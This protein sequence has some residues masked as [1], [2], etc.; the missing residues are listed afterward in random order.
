MQ[1][2]LSG[3]C[4]LANTAFG[5][6]HILRNATVKVMGNHDHIESFLGGVHGV[7]SCRARGRWD[8]LALPAHSD[9]V[10]SVPAAGAFGVKAVNSSALEGGDCIFDK[11]AL[12]Q[13]V[14]VDKN[15]HVHVIRDGEAAIDCG[16]RR[17]P[18]FMKFQAARAGL[19]LLNQTRRKTGIALSEKAEIDW[20][21]VG[22][23]EHAP[24]VPRSW[25]TGGGSRTG[26]WPGSS[27]HHRGKAG[28]KRLFDLLR[29]DVMNMHVDA[30]SSDNIAFAGNHLGSRPDDKRHIGLH[31]GIASLADRGNTPILKPDIGF[32]NSPVIEY[33]RVGDHCINCAFAAGMLRLAHAVADDFT[34]SELYLLA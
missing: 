12:V 5:E 24:N 25:R 26:R 14:G 18:V 21:G 9:D 15:L 31:I 28:I 19:N 6:G 34:T 3:N 4:L 16:G 27:A 33:E 8:N 20:E 11:A 1:D 22:G 29:A 7:G 32:N 10:R 23:L 17:A 13:R 30:T 2:V